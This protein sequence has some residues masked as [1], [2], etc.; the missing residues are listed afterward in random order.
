MIKVFIRAR[1]L[2]NLNHLNNEEIRESLYSLKKT[3]D[4]FKHG[5]RS[6][7]SNV[8]TDSLDEYDAPIEKDIL[9]TVYSTSGYTNQDV[10]LLSSR[11]IELLG[12]LLRTK[13]YTGV[14][15]DNIVKMLESM[16]SIYQT[17]KS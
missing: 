3:L 13:Y 5:I 1:Y 12:L 16:H 8:F 10:Q 15:R 11:I 14:E 9:D 17:Y 2:D 7:F 6:S 4:K